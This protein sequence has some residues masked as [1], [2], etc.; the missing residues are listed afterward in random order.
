M[1]KCILMAFAVMLST[2]V[3]SG[4]SKELTFNNDGHFKIAQFTD[5]H[6]HMG[7]SEYRA[8]ETDKTFARISRVVRQEKPDL[9]VFTGDVVTDG[10]A[11]TAWTRLMDSLNVFKVPFCVVFGNHDPEQELTKAEMSRIITSSPYSLNT[12]NKN[13][14]LAD[15][16]VKV[17]G[18]NIKKPELN[19]YFMDSHDYSTIETVDGYGWFTFEQVEWFRNSCLKSNEANG[20]KPVNSLAF[21][22]ICLPEY[23]TAWE[24]SDSKVG[25]RAEDPCPSALNSGL[26]AAMA[27]TGGVMGVFVGHDH[28]ND[29]VAA[30][31]GIALGYGRY[32]GSNTTYN[33][34]RSGVRLITVKEGVRAFESWILE[35]D[36]RTV[37]HMKFENG[38]IED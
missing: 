24:E 34:L 18:S 8:L 12:L 31:Q 21:F 16:E 20:G 3:V 37:D 17:N 2:L 9:I 14:E 38:K 4:Q 35:D 1:R 10:D 32:S 25:R 22:H 23:V 33:N 26:F 29:Y 6:M 5:T 11:K 19:L 7:G 36:G 27:Q 30:Y 13:K 28:D 15:I